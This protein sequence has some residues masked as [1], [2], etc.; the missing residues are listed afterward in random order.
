MKYFSYYD[1]EGNEQEI[2]KE[3]ALQRIKKEYT[4]P[5]EVLETIEKHQGSYLTIT[6]SMRGGYI[7]IIP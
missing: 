2:T 4:H 6:L 1:D 7:L 5:K 3:K